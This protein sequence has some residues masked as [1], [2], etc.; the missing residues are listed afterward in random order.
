MC[1]TSTS[2]P[3]RAAEVLSPLGHHLPIPKPL[4]LLPRPLRRTFGQP[5]LEH[6]VGEES[7][8]IAHVR[9]VVHGGAAAVEGRLAGL[10]EEE[11]ILGPCE[12]VV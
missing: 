10:S 5:S 2:W 11:G 7:S 8:E 12:R 1:V 3:R 4:L 9:K 6:V